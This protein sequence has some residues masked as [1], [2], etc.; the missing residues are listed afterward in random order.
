MLVCV[1]YAEVTINSVSFLSQNCAYMNSVYSLLTI[2]HHC[3]ELKMETPLMVRA[4]TKGK[5][6]GMKEKTAHSLGDILC[7]RTHGLPTHAQ[8]GFRLPLIP[9]DGILV[10]AYS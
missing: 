9:S 4:Q 3:G 2:G 7:V 5:V 10:S 1:C 8:I 6:L